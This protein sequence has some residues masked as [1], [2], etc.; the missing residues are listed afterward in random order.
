MSQKIKAIHRCVEFLTEQGYYGD[1][2][3][4][5][6]TNGKNTAEYLCERF[7]TSNGAEVLD[8]DYDVVREWLEE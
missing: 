3:M 1:F 6:A 2:N 7:T 4:L 8:S 5:F